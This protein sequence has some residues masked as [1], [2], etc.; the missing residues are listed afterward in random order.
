MSAYE[1][2]FVSAFI[3]DLYTGHKEEI[4]FRPVYNSCMNAYFSLKNRYRTLFF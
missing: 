4:Q 1:F 2:E 3:H